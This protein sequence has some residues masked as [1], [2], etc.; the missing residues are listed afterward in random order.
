MQNRNLLK[1]LYLTIDPGLNTAIAIWTNNNHLID[2]V[3]FTINKYK[4]KKDMTIE[5]K[6][7]LMRLFLSSKIGKYL[8][9]IN[10]VHIESVELWGGSSLSYMAGIRGD[11]FLLSYLVGIYFEFFISKQINTYLVSAHTWKGQ[12]AYNALLIRVTNILK[13]DENTYSEHAINALGLGLYT[14]GRLK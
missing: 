5:H 11:L 4:H 9:Y 6:L 8:N 3:E 14:Q 12:L 2:T 10:H 1:N 13:L 7:T